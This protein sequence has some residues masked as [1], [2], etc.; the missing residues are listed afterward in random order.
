MLFNNAVCLNEKLS[1]IDFKPSTVFITRSISF[2]IIKSTTFGLP[3][4]TFLTVSQKISLFFR[5][6]DVPLVAIKSKPKLTKDF[7]GSII[8]IYLI[9]TAA[10]GATASTLSAV[11]NA[12]PVSIANPAIPY[13]VLRNN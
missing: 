6:F 12:A 8:F 3:S 5:K 10:N 1:S 7:A 4:K 11:T 9:C 13:L 2:E